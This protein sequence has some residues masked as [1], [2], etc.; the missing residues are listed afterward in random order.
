VTG[1][2]TISIAATRIEGS[3]RHAGIVEGASMK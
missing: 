1:S 2:P 3:A